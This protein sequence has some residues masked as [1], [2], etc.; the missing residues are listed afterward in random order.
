[1]AA[2]AAAGELARE[3]AVLFERHAARVDNSAVVALRPFAVSDVS[4]LDAAEHNHA[5]GLKTELA[6]VFDKHADAL[7]EA[8]FEMAVEIGRRL[9]LQLGMPDTAEAVCFARAVLPARLLK[10]PP[11]PRRVAAHTAAL[12][13]RAWAAWRRVRAAD[14]ALC[15][16][17]SRERLLAGLRNLSLHGLRPLLAMCEDDRAASYW[18]VQSSSTVALAAEAEADP[19]VVEGVAFALGHARFTLHIALF[20][21]TA[22]QSAARATKA[23]AALEKRFPRAE[24]RALALASA[25][26]ITA[27]FAPTEEGERGGP[28]AARP[29]RVVAER[30]AAAGAAA[31]LLDAA[32]PLVAAL[33]EAAAETVPA[34]AWAALWCGGLDSMEAMPRPPAT[35]KAP[36]AAPGVCSKAPSRGWPHPD[37]VRRGIEAPSSALREADAAAVFA[38]ERHELELESYR[39]LKEALAEQRKQEEAAAAAA[40]AEEEAKAEAAAGSAG[41]KGG[42]GG[43]AAKK[44]GKAKKGAAAAEEAARAEAAAAEARAAK[45]AEEAAEAAAASAM[46]PDDGV[47]GALDLEA[48]PAAEAL[49]LGVHMA[50]LRAMA[51]WGRWE[52]VGDCA[53]LLCLRAAQERASATAAMEA[54]GGRAVFAA[55]GGAVAAAPGAGPVGGAGGREA[56]TEAA[57][58]EAW[59]DEDET[60]RGGAGSQLAATQAEAALAAATARL[61]LCSRY[62][63][64]GDDRA[65]ARAGAAAA[66]SGSAP[67]P[68]ADS[69]SDAAAAAKP[70]ESPSVL[71]L[72]AAS[73]PRGSA[74][75]GLGLG[76]GVVAFAA[77]CLEL[78]TAGEG[79]G[80]ALLAPSLVATATAA[81]WRCASAVR[82]WL[83]ARPPSLLRDR[84]AKLAARGS[85][86]LVLSAVAS[87][88]ES[89]AGSVPDAPLPAVGS[90]AAETGIALG[91]L[92]GERGDH[93][94]AV[95]A[96]RRGLRAVETSRGVACEAA[97]LNTGGDWRALAS[98]A[99]QSAG[100]ALA[101]G[102]AAPAA[103]ATGLS[104]PAPGSVLSPSEER[105]PSSA[106]WARAVLH[107]DALLSAAD[108]ETRLAAWTAAA[109][110]AVNARKRAARAAAKAAAMRPPKPGSTLRRKPAGREAPPTMVDTTRTTGGPALTARG[111]GGGAGDGTG[112]DDDDDAAAN[113]AARDGL[114]P[115][116]TDAPPSGA[117]LS[118]CA[119]ATSRP[120]SRGTSEAKEDDDDDD[121]DDNGGEG[122][123]GRG[124]GPGRSPRLG[125]ASKAAGRTA[126]SASGAAA[127]DEAE[128]LGHVDDGVAAAAAGRR[129][130]VRL[131]A[132]AYG[133]G[134]EVVATSTGWRQGS[135]SWA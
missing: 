74:L 58:A 113:G 89:A 20:G 53:A 85:L 13:G 77:G 119:L 69:A 76:A 117:Q 2:S 91:L 78:A 54:M 27:Q 33:G 124:S 38:A 55:T 126:A 41:K 72:V 17:S 15:A 10:T 131:L 25:L 9:T 45:E 125:S 3:C 39:A 43:S 16:L 109:V 51:V 6:A 108:A 62:G 73:A 70:A 46:C 8:L 48:S 82:A 115:D 5:D 88:A 67:S 52:E 81:L 114:E 104:R 95:T 64:D 50:L 40:A 60:G 92:L 35:G 23:V 101:A 65:A 79:G 29:G 30:E 90:L 56:A 102:A 93:R 26:A 106:E 19:P 71:E 49:P 44:D 122:M 129:L 24:H 36:P 98:V 123:R 22:A 11:S 21:V 100:G 118:K 14:P 84:A 94:G 96:V 37:A 12:A 47:C 59:G 31:V 80:A 57:A 4:A 42:K 32:A 120:T 116:P 105:P 107:T 128:A 112:D 61:V 111:A 7:G 110:A 18:A 68:A 134:T 127:M 99:W 86:A 1:M 66:S 87:G 130:H 63:P 103:G 121:V 133:A 97:A 28:V 75:P 34:A 135:T 132:K 83:N